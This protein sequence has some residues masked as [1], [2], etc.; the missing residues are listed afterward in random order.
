MS[1]C[2]VEVRVGS[3]VVAAGWNVVITMERITMF[4]D[5]VFFEVV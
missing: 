5:M 1:P 3:L 2:V 4:C